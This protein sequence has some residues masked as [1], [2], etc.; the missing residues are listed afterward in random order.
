MGYKVR[1]Q[2]INRSSNY[3]YCV[4]V[5]VVLVETAGLAKGEELEWTLED[6]NTFVLTR[7]SPVPI[8]RRQS[9]SKGTAPEC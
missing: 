3:T 4:T 1:L 8:K 2:K 5:P 6:K 9:V 7:R